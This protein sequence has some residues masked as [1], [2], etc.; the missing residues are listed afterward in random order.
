M[1]PRAS[2]IVAAFWLCLSAVAVSGPV[3]R[4]QP[5]ANEIGGWITENLLSD[6]EL[7]KSCAEAGY[8]NRKPDQLDLMIGQMIMV[9]FTGTRPNDPGTQIL[10]RLVSRGFLG[11]VFFAGH[12]ITGKDQIRNLTEHFANAATPSAPLLG[13]DQEGGFV[14]RLTRKTGHGN[15]LAAQRVAGKMSPQRA[16]A[17]YR[18]LA[19]Q[20]AGAGFNVNF[21]PVVDL[22]VTGRKN[23]IIG[24]Q[25]RSYGNDQAVVTSY[26]RAF[27]RAHRDFG[28]L[29]SAKHFPGHGSS[30]KDSHKGFTSIPRWDPVRE[31]HPYRQLAKLDSSGRPGV[32]MIMVGHLHNPSYSANSK[33]ATLEYAA[34]HDLIRR[35]LSFTGVTIT[36]DMQMRAI[37][38]NYDWRIAAVDAV[39]AGNDILLFANIDQPDPG[40]ACKL[41][42]VMVRAVLSD[43]ISRMTVARSHARIQAMKAWLT[44]SERPDKDKGQ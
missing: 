14:Q 5:D 26:A 6:D 41:H 20:V 4:A 12:N 43:D 13:L 36:D 3:A 39:K 35:D 30:L 9:G 42:R 27:V 1:T 28:V 22:D 7:S 10:H 11:G 38:D 33:P 8:F 34:V 21:G 17:Y 29:T 44:R 32:D 18:T 2:T 15:W 40:L 37:R 19:R 25:Q 16:Y 31:L 24:R 23:P